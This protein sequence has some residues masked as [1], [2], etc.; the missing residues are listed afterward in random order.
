MLGTS[1]FDAPWYTGLADTMKALLRVSQRLVQYYEAA[2]LQPSLDVLTDN[3]LFLVLGHQLLST[4]YTPTPAG[5]LDWQTVSYILNEPLRITLFIYLNM[6]IWNFQ[7]YPIMRRL[8]NSLQDALLRIAILSPTGSPVQTPTPAPASVL[9]HVKNNAPDVL[10]WIL[11][12]GAMASHGHS[13]H[14]WFVH[15]LAD[16]AALLEL[17]EWEMAREILGGF[18]FTDQPGQQRGEELWKQV[19]SSWIDGYRQS[20]EAYVVV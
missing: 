13:P 19:V 6:R 4:R 2:R 7:E 1:F 18:F 14:S 20:E 15:Q 10:F 12:I 8:V 11:F 3:S 16:L 17:R 9:F 5:E